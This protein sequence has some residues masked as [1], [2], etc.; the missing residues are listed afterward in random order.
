MK[1][2]LE[3]KIFIKKNKDYIL[4]KYGTDQ[5]FSMCVQSQYD[6]DNSTMIISF[7]LTSHECIG[8]LQLV[9]WCAVL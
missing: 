3:V 7:T 6:F 9:T 4:K 1:T 5:G 8:N 2:F